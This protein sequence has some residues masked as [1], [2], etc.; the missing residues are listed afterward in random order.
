MELPSVFTWT[1]HFCPYPNF[2]INREAYCA[3]IPA[4]RR[5]AVGYINQVRGRVV[6]SRATS[7]G[8]FVVGLGTRTCACYFRD[9]SEGDVKKVLFASL[10]FLV[11]FSFVFLSLAEL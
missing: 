6:V 9:L 1:K 2:Q 8:P 5:S 3:V 10:V 4:A 11:S 7:R